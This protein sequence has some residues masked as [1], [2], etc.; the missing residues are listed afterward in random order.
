MS[1]K[2]ISET[3]QPQSQ[4]N[5]V[6]LLD[7]AGVSCRPGPPGVHPKPHACWFCTKK[8]IATNGVIAGTQLDAFASTA[9]LLTLFPVLDQALEKSVI[10]NQFPVS[11]SIRAPIPN[12]L[13]HRVGRHQLPHFSVDLHHPRSP[14][15][16]SPCGD[17]PIHF[18]SFVLER[19]SQSRS[20]CRRG[21]NTI[22]K[23]GRA[24][25]SPTRHFPLNTVRIDAKTTCQS[26]GGNTSDLLTILRQKA[27]M[28]P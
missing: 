26:C 3:P 15:W 8:S 5:G 28:L 10:T 21:L 19:R 25:A 23:T 20:I 13:L 11:C 2:L 24:M 17:T 14:L 9:V 4:P 1:F 12:D 18:S 7:T 6:P 22:D 27:A 16:H